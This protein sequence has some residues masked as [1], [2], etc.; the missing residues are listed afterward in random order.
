ME[1][2]TYL[3]LQGTLPGQERGDTGAGCAPVSQHPAGGHTGWGKGGADGSGGTGRTGNYH[4]HFTEGKAASLELES[5]KPELRAP[6]HGTESWT[7]GADE[8]SA[9]CR[10]TRERSGGKQG[11]SAHY[12]GNTGIPHQGHIA[13][14]IIWD[15]PHTCG[16]IIFFKI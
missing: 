15:V 6:S 13:L 4:S 5:V 14:W 11:V 1:C 7:S 10:G 2:G 16:R 9:G 12:G 8:D 3:L